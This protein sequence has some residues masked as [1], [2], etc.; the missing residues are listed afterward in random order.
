[1]RTLLT[2]A[3]AA[4]LL[5]GCGSAG[6]DANAPAP[7]RIGLLLALTGNNGSIGQDVRDGFEL[8]L[9]EHGEKLGGH[10]VD[11]R[12]EDEG[13]TPDSARAA[14]RLLLNDHAAAIVGP[15][16]G[17]DYQGVSDLATSAKVPLVG[18][19]ARPDLHDIGYV[20][21]VG[22]MSADPGTAIGPYVKQHAGSPAFA[23]SSDEPG[24]WEQIKGFMD[25]YTQAGGA[26]ANP[27]GVPTTTMAGTSD[28]GP[29]FRMIKASGAKAVYCFYTGQQA[30]DFV[31]AYA[32]SDVHTIPLY[33][34][35]FLT[36]GTLLHSE[37][38]AAENIDTVMDYS[39]DVDTAANRAFVSSW[40]AGHAGEQPT[41]FAMTGF[42]AAAMLDRAIGTA[43]GADPSPQRINSAIGTLGR[44]DSPRGAWQMAP[45]THAPVQKWYLRRVQMDGSAL[46]NVEIEELATIGG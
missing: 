8:Y 30:V 12:L 37:G 33:A 40:T 31:R 34:P 3:S 17:P 35:G 15:V 7:I 5:A 46:A 2:L 4:A 25:G 16:S 13:P 27:N 19:T 44:I 20:W 38:A 18:V 10:A 39:P 28:F 6:A 43:G 29:Y 21:D 11:I 1:V 24:A 32:A 42:D 36:E 9:S 14:T 26:L 45:G 41:V 23:I 22:F